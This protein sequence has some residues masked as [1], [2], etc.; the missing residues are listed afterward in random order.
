MEPEMKP[1]SYQSQMEN[2]AL[3][4]N[5]IIFLPTGSGK[6]F[7]AIQLIKRLQESTKA[8]YSKGS[9]RIFFLVNT[10]PL[11]SQHIKVVE[12]LTSLSVKGFTSQDKIDLWDQNEWLLQLENVQVIIIQSKFILRTKYVYEKNQSSLCYLSI[13]HL[14]C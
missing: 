7:I 13:L 11:V 12:N 4:E 1:R 8:P 2:I 10:V 5:S 3:N 9:K 14:R 6:T